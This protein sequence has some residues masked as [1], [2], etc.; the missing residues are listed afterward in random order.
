MYQAHLNTK[1]L[2]SK[3]RTHTKTFH[4]RFALTMI[5][6][7]QN[8]CPQ[9]DFITAESNKESSP[10]QNNGHHNTNCEDRKTVNNIP[11]HSTTIVD[12]ATPVMHVLNTSALQYYYVLQILLIH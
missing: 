10:M 8:I 9:D 2:F 5:A 12:T 6:T 7:N 11:S 1:S 3:T 4:N